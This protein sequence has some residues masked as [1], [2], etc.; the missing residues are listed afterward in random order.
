MDLPALRAVVT[1]AETLHFGRAAERLDIAQ[2]QVSQRVRRLERE[3]GFPLFDRGHH[4]VTL[5]SGGSLIVDQAR[6]VLA[7]ADR[8]EVLA[9][10]IASGA[11]GVVRI[12]V[13]GSAL[14][15]A[16][17][18]LLAPCRVQFPE[19]ELNVRE[20]ET[21]EQVAAMNDGTLDLGFLRP[22]A[23]A[24]MRTR[25]VWSEPLVVA[26]PAAHPLTRRECIVGKDLG[27][28]RIV[29]LPREAGPGYWDQAAAAVTG[30]GALLEPSDTADHVTT[31][32]GMVALGTGMT[33]VPESMRTLQLP[34]VE[35]RPLEPTA[36]IDL[37]VAMPISSP[38]PAAAQVLDTLPHGG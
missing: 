24:G 9:D 10:G 23:P 6:R 17:S 30:T 38:T 21:P 14:F 22:P 31:L 5:T 27:G 2:P 26:L 4:V 8:L 20:M 16:L 3:L 19:L 34:G 13:V 33:L 25:V 1:V 15:G 18:Q 12:G 11:A 37:A 32:L 29:M 7:A 28:Q 35:Y 36:V